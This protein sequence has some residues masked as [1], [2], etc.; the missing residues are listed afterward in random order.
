MQSLDIKLV[1]GSSLALSCALFG[2][3]QFICF[4]Y[5]PVG[6]GLTLLVIR[7]VNVACKSSLVL[8]DCLLLAARRYAVLCCTSCINGLCTRLGDWAALTQYSNAHQ[9]DGNNTTAVNGQEEMKC[10]HGRPG[11]FIS[12]SESFK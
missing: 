5:L 7:Q 11:L 10:A 1:V 8:S 2:L 4:V 12:A 6:V 3:I 9:T